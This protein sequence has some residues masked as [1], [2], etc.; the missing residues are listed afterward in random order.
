MSDSTY[1]LVTVITPTYNRGPFLAETIESVLAQNYP[2]LEYIVLDDGSTDDTLAVV[3]PYR[4]RLRYERHENQGE[5]RTVNKGWSKARGDF[6]MVVNSDDPILPGLLPTAVEFMERHP[7]LLMV[8]PDWIVIDAKSKPIQTVQALDYDYQEM[9]K[10]WGCV[11]GP[12]ALMRRRA[13]ELEPSRDIRYRYVADFEYWLRLGLHGPFARLP[14]VLATHRHHGDSAGVAQ[15]ARI[16]RELVALAHEFFDRPGL[17]DDIRRLRRR[18]LASAHF[19]A[20]TRCNASFFGYYKHLL[21]S[22]AYHPLVGLTKAVRHPLVPFRIHF[23]QKWKPVLRQ[24][25]PQK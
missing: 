1:P 13:I 18:A 25:V 11:P 12:G 16:A 14:K 10:I 15:A 21:G 2:N 5:T 6:I 3:R 20:A 22:I 4:H 7:E 24:F 9:I 8:Y 23:A 19:D 17:P